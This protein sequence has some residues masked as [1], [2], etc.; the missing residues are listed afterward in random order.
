M[1]KKILILSSILVIILSN[2]S[3]IAF[4]GPIFPEPT[5]PDSVNTYG[6]IFPEPT[7]D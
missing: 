2:L 3:S 7:K 4:A 1:K 6:V 5:R